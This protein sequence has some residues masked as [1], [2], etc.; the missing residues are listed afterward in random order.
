MRCFKK[1]VKQ[2]VVTDNRLGHTSHDYAEQL[3][4]VP[5]TSG[6]PVAAQNK[7]S[8]SIHSLNQLFIFADIANP[9]GT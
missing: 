4:E 8:E 9:Q 3:F 2:G 6:K 5:S 1:L 7:L